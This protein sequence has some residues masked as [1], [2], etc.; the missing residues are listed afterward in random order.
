MADGIIAREAELPLLE[1][2]ASA[3]ADGPRALVLEGE[4]GIGK[5]TLWAAGVS[6]ARRHARHVLTSRPAETEANLANVV[7]ADLFSELA[8]D[9]LAPLPA[10]RR[11]AL[12]SALLIGDVADAAGDPRA[13]GAAVLSVLS[14]LAAEGTVV[15]AIDDDQWADSSSTGSLAFALRRLRSEPVRLLLARRVEPSGFGLG[16]A[17]HT[18]EAA[19][20]AA[21]V[22]RAP[23]GPLSVGAVQ[24]LLRRRLG[25]ELSRASL[26]RLHE[27]S[28]GNPFFALELAR[29]MPEA[30]DPTAPLFV[31]PSLEHLLRG[32]LEGLD[33]GVADALLLVS[34]HG[35]APAGLLATLGVDPAVV[36]RA[37]ALQLL[38]SSGGVVRFS[39]SL[40]ASTVYQRAS[41]ADRRV[42]HLRLAVG[43][44]DPIARARHL[45]LGT[46]PP[47]EPVAAT[48][49]AAAATSRSRRMPMAAA[50]LAEH[51]VRLT[52]A[53]HVEDRVRRATT[54]A[55]AH[56]EAG[57]AGRA[58]DIVSALLTKA[59]SGPLRAEVLVLASELEEPAPAVAL[60]H[61]ALREAAASPRL[62]SRIHARMGDVGRFMLG[63][64][65]AER[66]ALASARLA[67]RLGDDAL[68]ARA[69]SGLA[70]LRFEHADPTALDL[71]LEARQRA[72]TLGD[73][74]TIATATLVVAHQLTWLRR[75]DE[76]RD[77]LERTIAEAADRDELRRSDALWYL[78]LVE[79]WAGRWDTA[80]EHAREAAAVSL[81]YG[82][83][84]P[85]D[86]L[87]LALVALHRGQFDA[88]REQS[89]LA[90]ALAEGM[91]APTH[92]AVL[93]I[94]Q[95][96]SGHPEEAVAAFATV[97]AIE[98][99]RGALGPG[100]FTGRAEHIEALLQV[101]RIDEATRLAAAW[102]D[103][104]RRAAHAWV[105]AEVVRSRGLIAASRGDLGE[106]A[107]L[108]EI[109]CRDHA[110]V[111]D[112]FGE[113]R[114]RL[115]LGV[116]HRRRRQKRAA[117]EAIHAAVE[118]FAALGAESWVA[119]ARSE[120]RR[121]GGQVR[122]E[123][124]SPSE[125]RVAELAGEGRTNREI[126]A[127]L[128]LGERTV[129][130]HLTHAYAKLG[131]R[132]RTELARSLRTTPTKDQTF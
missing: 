37:V 88:A 104:A 57:E 70:L 87:P 52:P 127:A 34:A 76:A 27:A 26:R 10:P 54:A 29:A 99:R 80:A 110:A 59:P 105:L 49:E 55:R 9:V 33:A 100:F 126:A 81:A 51:A 113:A 93:A 120:L 41:P 39:H 83:E 32:R 6:A 90:L 63:R 50:E 23:V 77:L 16:A 11:R 42:A 123:G 107:S 19:I 45:A 111:G 115:A 118:V 97:A 21:A 79:L 75:I 40:L 71:A 119:G 47:D 65:A 12:E 46:A 22:E 15:I 69:L 4:P 28:G 85:Q 89:M 82:I 43:V 35:R 128:F 56:V 68:R 8:P 2:F 103:L 31:P 116:V 129:A 109:A 108:L 98:D 72:V 62:R 30:S 60:L 7:L 25:L 73:P 117:R 121:I 3:A 14:S 66:H 84:R 106:A 125:R 74:E 78:S 24:L 53:E 96:W 112:A 91:M 58:R 101:G 92:L 61:D 18:L 130:S 132:S 67:D 38:D 48:V 124:L 95:L 122:I 102:E 5:S 64:D 17:A 13:L 114:A 131:V 44:E 36:E 20:D 94:A 86:H 1:A